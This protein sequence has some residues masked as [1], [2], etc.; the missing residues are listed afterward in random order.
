MGADHAAAFLGGILVRRGSAELDPTNL[1]DAA[2]DWPATIR[3]AND[4]FACPALWTALREAGAAAAVPH[5]VRDYLGWLHAENARCNIAIRDQCAAIGTLLESLDTSAALLK[6]A[7]W[8]FE[9][10]PAG[11]DRMMRDIDLLVDGADIETARHALLRAG[12]FPSPTAPAEEGNIHDAPLVHP[13]RMVSVELHHELTTRVGLL[14]GRDVLADSR[15]IAPGLRM[16]STAHRIIHNVIHAQIVNGDFAGGVVD[17]RD[18]LDLSRL[19][20]M[21]AQ[22]LDWHGLAATAR[23]RGYFRELSGALHKAARFTGLPLPKPF[24]SDHAGRRHA[25]R[26]AWQRRFPVLD[27]PLRRLGVVRRA[28]VWERD[29]YA[30]G[31]GSDR[32][33]I[34]HLKVNRRRAQR[35]AKAVRRVLRRLV[36]LP[37][38]SGDFKHDASVRSGD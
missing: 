32:T 28:L 27:R 23:R 29:S 8:L 31:L 13:E 11:G 17:F 20:Q 38:R 21:P 4:G 2:I 30:L 37:G 19:A 24:S 10:G 15:S 9:A 7:A 18:L 34:A 1:G 16:P 26:C 36:S 6:G 14:S 12:Y 5:D 35:L 33:V 3:H 25:A 22:T